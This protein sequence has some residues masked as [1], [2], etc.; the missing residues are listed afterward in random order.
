MGWQWASC[1]VLALLLGPATAEAYRFRGDAIA[2]CVVA[3]EGAACIGRETERC[4]AVTRG[5]SA[6]A[7]TA[8]TGEE[9]ARWQDESAWMLEAE[10]DFL[11]AW[12]AREDDCT[13]RECPSGVEVPDGMETAWRTY[14]EA[15]CRYD[16]VSFRG[17]KDGRTVLAGCLLQMTG[18]QVLSLRLGDGG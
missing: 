16:T 6:R 10:R 12:D 4:I 17:T 8:C 7:M 1:A 3:G 14:R 2:A 15:R 5:F 18:E 9:I 13:T 11:R